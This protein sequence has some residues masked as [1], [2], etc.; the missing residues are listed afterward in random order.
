MD[1]KADDGYDSANPGGEFAPSKISD[2]NL[3]WRI[4][5]TYDFTDNFS[6]FVQYSQ[7]FKV[8]PYDLAY[9]YFEHEAFCDGSQDTCYRD[10][11]IPA[12][13]SEERRVGKEGEC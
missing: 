5:T 8:P 1:P 11:I 2:S 6:A 3:S 13:R 10:R 7:G 12:D 4:G 9:F